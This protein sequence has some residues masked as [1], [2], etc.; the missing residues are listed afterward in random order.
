M[1]I[2]SYDP[3]IED[4]Y[5]KQ[6]E[7]DVSSNPLL[8]HHNADINSLQGKQCILEMYA[9]LILTN[10]PLPLLWKLTRLALAASILQA[11]N[12]LVSS[13]PCLQ[14]ISLRNLLIIIPSCYEVRDAKHLRLNIDCNRSR[15]RQQDRRF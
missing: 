1:W 12:N 6:I 14:A 2:E 4:S 11:Q 13:I 10:V 7:V 8:L 5:R 3:T 15:R 9:L